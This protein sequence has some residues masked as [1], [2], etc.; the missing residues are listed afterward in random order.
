MTHSAK[1]ASSS[2][3][4]VLQTLA[5][6]RRQG[7]H[8]VPLHVRSKAAISRAY[9]DKDYKPPADEFWQN[10]DYGIG[11]VTG[12][13][14]SGP[15][16]VDLDCDEAVF[17]ARVFLPP[18]DAVFGRAGK[19]ASHYLYRVEAPQFEKRAF[20]D[21]IP[22]PT[23]PAGEACIIEAR[24]DNGHQTVMPGS[25]HEGTGELI[26]W[27]TVPFP[28]VPT[29][30]PDL[31]MRAIRKVAV[32]TLI[33]R[34]VWQPGYHN[35]PCKHLSGVFFY[36][37][38][39]QDEAE[40]M[41]RAVMDLTGDADKS[42][43]PTVRT[44]YKRAAQGRKVSGAGVLRKEL[45]NDA[46]VDRLLDWAGSPTVNLLQ[47]YNERF[48]VVNVGGRF[49]IAD[50]DVA[51]GEPPTFYPKDDFLNLTATDYMTIDDKPV[52]KGKVWLANARRR[53]YRSVDFLPG[54][55]ESDVLNLWTGWA[56]KPRD[57]VCDAWIDLVGEVICGGDEQLYN[58]LCHW[59]ANIVREPMNKSLTAPVIVGVE[60]AGK[61]L[62]L[63]YFGR[64]L[65]PAYVVVTKEDHIVGR[66]NQHMGSTL[67]LHSEEALYAGDKKHAGIIR[68]LI[69]D[70]YHMFE[71][72]GVDAKKVRNFLRLALTSNEV[73]AAP[74]KPG[75]RRYTVIDM[76]DRIASQKLIK[77]VLEEMQGDGPAA[78]H[79]AL[80]NM[81]YDP[82]ICRTNVKNASL[83][84]LKTTNLTPVENWWMDVLTSGMVLPDY[85]NW[86]TKPE[87]DDWPEVVS[88]VALHVSM[89]LKLR[90]RNV[91]SVPSEQVLAFNLARFI[92]AALHKGQRSY[93]NPL[94]DDFPQPVKMMNARQNSILNMP[95]LADCRA[96]FE[97][98]LG[99]KI[100]W[101]KDAPP[102]APP[103]ERPKHDK[104]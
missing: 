7:F 72:K 28:D 80:L 71:Q 56:V 69:T 58:W 51:A 73:Y 67:L 75:D 34:H 83:L 9:V 59:F 70:P 82:A 85:L 27:D 55:E 61:S 36:L 86:A 94:L 87:K 89:M 84:S 95:S 103:T 88:S 93:D 48:A 64:I 21:P 37:D 6:M 49:R 66:F 45:K 79:H 26:R 18:T 74:A 14:H 23:A 47:E 54:V 102:T 38:W 22:S 13:A 100:E 76:G 104:F 32:A 44:T 30:A 4:A 96:A 11:I 43:L 65:G 60:G 50:V 101:P 31:L 12:P 8:P 81:E 3:D 42:R 97:K 90:E 78:L 33:A 2:S 39:S 40:E 35:A 63:N 19:P 25:L 17:F 57:G 91:R 16:D 29:V 77:A 92:G 99:Q 53:S 62:M 10:N 52:S 46:L 24:G 41:I 20:N 98:Y 15:V 68:S 5:W 1:P